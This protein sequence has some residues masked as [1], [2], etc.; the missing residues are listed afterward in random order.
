MKELSFW[1]IFHIIPK[2]DFHTV[3]VSEILSS[4]QSVNAQLFFAALKYIKIAVWVQFQLD[5][6]QILVTKQLQWIL[7]VT[8]ES[9]FAVRPTISSSITLACV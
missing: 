8:P 7:Q 5:F 3:Y 4:F 6:A 1:S 2:P 9:F